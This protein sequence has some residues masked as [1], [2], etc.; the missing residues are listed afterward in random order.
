M[1][2]PSGSINTYPSKDV[3][4]NRGTPTLESCCG[5]PI[6]R[7]FED[8]I[9]EQDIFPRCGVDLFQALPFGYDPVCFGHKAE[10][11]FSGAKENVGVY[12]HLNLTLG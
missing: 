5:S 12:E 7:I 2:D 3:K 9:E 4:N 11:V 10:A 1:T 6:R 8:G